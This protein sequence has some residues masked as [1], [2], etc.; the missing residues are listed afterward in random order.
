M[1]KNINLHLYLIISVCSLLITTPIEVL[2][3]DNN[4]EENLIHNTFSSVSQQDS[5]LQA[6]RNNDR[7]TREINAF[8]NSKYNS[9]DT[10]LLSQYWG[11]SIVDTKAR[12][13]RKVLWGDGGVPYLEQYLVTARVKAI[14][15]VYSRCSYLDEGY[16][17]KDAEAL[18][19]YWGESTVWQAKQRI[20]DN[21]M[22]GNQ[23]E[24][25]VALAKLGR[26]R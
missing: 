3:N 2:A 11:Q 15:G 1:I 6:Q 17:Y 21:L 20:E 25:D 8:A 26:R 24:V 13:G 9:C 19:K 7:Q 10:K 12:I 14:R 16:T 22:L 18:S 4:T 5:N 23:Q